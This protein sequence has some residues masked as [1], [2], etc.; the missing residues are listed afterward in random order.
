MAV[1]EG[2]LLRKAHRLFR[3]FRKPAAHIAILSERDFEEC[4]GLVESGEGVL[5]HPPISTSR[6]F[7]RDGPVS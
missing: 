7:R 3:D 5:W 4:A 2:W 1:R 6:E